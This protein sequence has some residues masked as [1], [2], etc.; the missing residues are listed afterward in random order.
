[1]YSLSSLWC[2][3]RTHIVASA[4][5]PPPSHPRITGYVLSSM[6]RL[7]FRAL[8]SKHTYCTERGSTVAR[9]YNHTRITDCGLWTFVSSFISYRTLVYYFI[10]P[11]YFCPFLFPVACFTV[12]CFCT[13]YYLYHFVPCLVVNP[14][15]SGLGPT[16]LAASELSMTRPNR[17]QAFVN[18]D[19]VWEK[20]T[21]STFC[22]P[23]TTLTSMRLGC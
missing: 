5:L 23:V 21:V 7:R 8:A 15:H 9:A 10:S 17:S 16:R 14:V 6:F 3:T 13:Y 4:R 12:Y 19:V 11:P 22:I 2:L 18:A 1:M 20:I